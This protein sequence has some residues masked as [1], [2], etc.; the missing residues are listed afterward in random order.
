MKVSENDV[1][2]NNTREFAK[3]YFIRTEMEKVSGVDEN[4]DMKTSDTVQVSKSNPFDEK[5]EVGQ[6]RLLSQL[7]R[8]T[9]V[10][11]MHTWGDEG[12]VVTPFSDYDDPATEQ[13][14]RVTSSVPR[15]TILQCWNT[16]SL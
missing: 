12:F 1:R 16:R 10:A 15:L 5:L 2:R 11:L 6:I 7:D 8:P 4:A 13:E 3:A 14:L 9:F